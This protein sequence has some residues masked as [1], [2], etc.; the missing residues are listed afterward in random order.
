MVMGFA[1]VVFLKNRSPL[2]ASTKKRKV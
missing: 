1:F 2:A